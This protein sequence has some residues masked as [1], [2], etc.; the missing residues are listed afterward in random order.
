MLD[1]IRTLLHQA[2]TTPRG[3]SVAPIRVTKAVAKSLNLMLDEPLCSAAE[4]DKRRAAAKR[5]I[6]LRRAP[7]VKAKSTRT[8]APVMVYFEKDRNAR[9]LAK[10]LEVLAAQS[11][12]P[13]LL[14]V[15]GD[16]ATMAFVM[17][18]AKCERDE[19]PAVFVAGT[20]V[21]GFRKL[22]A[23]NASGALKK[24]VFGE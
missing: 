15:S 6:E 14:D 17:R 11:I 22:V 24:A 20:A 18:E 1:S 23:A 10:I 9:E 16:E 5:L 4:L 12:E 2:I 21:G 8:P 3:D 19:L 13:K 7:R